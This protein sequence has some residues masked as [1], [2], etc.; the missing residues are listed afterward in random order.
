MA[1]ARAVQPVIP[2]VNVYNVPEKKSSHLPL[3][4]NLYKEQYHKGRFLISALAY[5]AS[6]QLFMI[7]AASGIA[8][9]LF[10]YSFKNLSK[11]IHED[12]KAYEWGPQKPHER[13][14]YFVTETA[15]LFGAKIS[16]SRAA[17][18]LSSAYSGYSTAYELTHRAIDCLPSQKSSK[19]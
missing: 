3:G 17:V 14:L 16:G 4:A 2:R 1:E 7:G 10:D 19:K 5:S 11:D 8:K 18:I 13:I 6:P 9:A 12:S 15:L